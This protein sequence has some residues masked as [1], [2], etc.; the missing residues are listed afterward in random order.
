MGMWSN[1]QVL[2]FILSISFCISL[3]ESGKKFLIS[4]TCSLVD[5]LN[6]SNPVNLSHIFWI[7]IRKNVANSSANLSQV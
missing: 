6:S 7:F 1:L 2:L 4:G 5:A 3:Q